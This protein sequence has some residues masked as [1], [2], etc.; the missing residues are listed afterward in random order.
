MKIDFIPL[1]VHGD[2]RGALISLEREKNIPFDIR[3]VYYIFDTKAGVTRGYHAHLKLKQVAIAVKGSCRFILDDGNER[4]SV[5]LDNPTQ[6]LLINSFIWRE[7]TDFSDD[8]V[9]MVLAD[10]EYEESDYIRDY[11]TFKL[12]VQQYQS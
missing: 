7:M 5:M 3:R 4:V 11:S 9:L 2:D 6:G 1:Q 10:M 8:C 12:M